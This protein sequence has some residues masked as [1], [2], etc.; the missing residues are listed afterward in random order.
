MEMMVKNNSV[1]Y[2]AKHFDVRKFECLESRHSDVNII[3]LKLKK[4]AIFNVA[5]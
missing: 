1:N 5:L 2:T 3:K 4:K